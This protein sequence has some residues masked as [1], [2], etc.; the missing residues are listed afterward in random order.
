MTDPRHADWAL[1][2]Q[3][4]LSVAAAYGAATQRRH[5]P[6]PGTDVFCMLVDVIRTTILPRRLCVRV[7]GTPAFDLAV[8]DGRVA[9]LAAVH[10]AK[11]FPGLAGFV[12]QPLTRDAASAFAEALCRET[13][14]AGDL[15]C[16]SGPNSAGSGGVPQ[17]GIHA[18]DLARLAGWDLV[19]GTVADRLEMLLEAFADAINGPPMP[20]DAA[21][22]GVDLETGDMLLIADDPSRDTI[23]Q[24]IIRTEDGLVVLQVARNAALT[25]AQFWSELPH[26]YHGLESAD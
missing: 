15:T 11:R 25:V 20:K 5:R 9:G 10:D 12:D 13:S 18:D 6:H 8:R 7:D 24:A 16:R 14:G 26:A 17:T 23:A 21:P 22:N 4:D 2:V 1:Q 3:R 19:Y